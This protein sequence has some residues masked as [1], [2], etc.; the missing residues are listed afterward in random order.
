MLDELSNG[1]SDVTCD[2]AQEGG[3]NIAAS[4]EGEGGRPSIGVAVLAMRP[5]LPH[6]GEPESLK[7]EGHLSRLQDGNISHVTPRS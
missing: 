3:R 2:P 5:F 1:E 6:L 7:D 4:V